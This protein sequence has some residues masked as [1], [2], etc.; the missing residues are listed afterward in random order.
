MEVLVPLIL[1]IVILAFLGHG[2]WVL[3]AWLLRA[4]FGVAAQR[5]RPGDSPQLCPRCLSPQPNKWDVCETCASIVARPDQ[6]SNVAL[7]A[8]QNHLDRLRTLGVLDSATYERFAQS[9]VAERRELMLPNDAPQSLSTIPDSDQTEVTEPV[10]AEAV[11]PIGPS[12]LAEPVK[13][14]PP[15]TPV[16]PDDTGHEPR[17]Q[18]ERIREFAAKFR[19]PIADEVTGE[20]AVP[21]EPSEPR[22]AVSKL[23]AAFM[24]EHSIRWGEI[25]GGLLII[26]CSIALVISFWSEIAARPLLKFFI[27]NSVTA[28]LFAVGFYTDRRWQLQ[29]TSVG[30][31]I[32]AILLVPLNVLAIAAFT[33]ASPPSDVL[34]IVGELI[35]LIVFSAFTYFAARTVLPNTA[36]PAAIGV[37]V[38][39]VM[40]LLTRRFVHLDA[41]YLTLYLLALAPIASYWVTAGTGLRWLD[42]DEI[43]ADACNELFILFGLVTYATVLPLALFLYK[44]WPSPN[45]IHDMSPV[46]SLFAV[47]AVVVGVFAGRRLATPATTTARVVGTATGCAGGVLMGIAVFAAWPHPATLLPVTLIPGLLFLALAT[48]WKLPLAFYPTSLSMLVVWP[49]ILSVL[50]GTIGWRS[51]AE[52][53]MASMLSA[54]TG[55]LLIPLAGVMAA[56]AALLARREQRE[57]ARVVGIS[58][59]FVAAVCLTLVTWFGFGR[60]GDPYGITWTFAAIAIGTYAAA[61]WVNHYGLTWAAAAMILGAVAQGALFRWP[62]EGT[63]PIR[64]ALVALIHASICTILLGFAAFAR[65]ASQRTHRATQQAALVTSFVASVLLIIAWNSDGATAVLPIAAWVTAIWFFLAFSS[66]EPSMFAAFQTALVVTLLCISVR[67]AETDSWYATSRL[68]WLHPH[69][70]QRLG[71]LLSGFALAWSALRWWMP[72][73]APDSESATWSWDGFV[74]RL[75]GLVHDSRSCVDHYVAAFIIVLTAWLALYASVPGVAQELAPRVG[76][77]ATTSRFVPPIH[78]FEI[79]NVPSAEAGQLASWG[80]WV[81]AMGV[82]LARSSQWTSGV[83]KMLL[84]LLVALACPLASAR[85]AADVSV[86]SGLR[87][88]LAVFFLLASIPLWMRQRFPRSLA[89]FAVP[90]TSRR[91]CGIRE[92]TAA[93]CLILA[94]VL[95]PHLVMAIY[96]GTSAVSLAGVPVPVAGVLPSLSVVAGF[97]ILISAGMLVASRQVSEPR[98][99]RTARSMWLSHAG[100]AIAFVGIAPVLVAFLF[101]VAASLMKHPIV[102]PEPGSWFGQVGWSVAYVVPLLIIAV[103]LVGDAVRERS[104][105]LAFG[106]GILFQVAATAG[107]MLTLPRLGRT[108]DESAWINVAQINTIVAGLVSLSWLA[109]L[110]VVHRGEHVLRFAPKLLTSYVVISAT[111][112]L[113]TLL[114][115]LGQLWLDQVPAEWVMMVGGWL[116]WLAF[117]CVSIAMIWWGG[118]TVGQFG[119]LEL[120][121]AMLSAVIMAAATIARWDTSN[122]LAYHTVEL[123]TIMA[124]IVVV[125][126]GWKWISHLVSRHG[127]TK[128]AIVPDRVLMTTE[129]AGWYG[130][131]SVLGVIFALRGAVAD[132]MAHW[133]SV[134]TIAAVACSSAL[135]AWNVKRRAL[136]LV[137]GV[138]WSIGGS[139]WWLL[140]QLP[141]YTAGIVDVPIDFLHFNLV[142]ASVPIAF[143]LVFTRAKIQIQNRGSITVSYHGFAAVLGILTFGL[144]SGVGLAA[145]LIG[146]PL[147]NSPWLGVGAWLVLMA[148]AIGWHV[149]R[150]GTA[151]ALITYVVG[152]LGLGLLQDRLDTT[153][154]LFWWSATMLLAAYGLATSYLWSQREKLQDI[155]ASTAPVPATDVSRSA[156]PRGSLDGQSPIGSFGWIVL[157]NGCLAAIVVAL[158]GWIDLTFETLALRVPASHAVL[159]QAFSLALL[160]KGTTRTQLQ[161]AAL[162]LGAVFAGVF[163]WSWLQPNMEATVLH[164]AVVVVV[165][166]SAVAIVYGFGLIKLFKRRNDWVTAAEHLVPV[167]V[168]VGFMTLLFVAGCEVWHYLNDERVPIQ[169]AAI[170]AV[171]IAL[172]GVCVACLAAALLPGRDPIGLSERGREV[173]VYAAEFVLALLCMHIRITMPW[174]FHGWFTRFWPLI[175]MGIAF[176]GVGYGELMLRRREGVLAHPLMTTGALLPVL[177]VLSWVFPSQVNYAVTL[178]SVAAL[179]ATLS[180]LRKSFLYAVLATVA[181]NGSLWYL[182]HQ[183]EELAF[184]RHPQFWLIPPALCTLV[185]SHLCRRQLTDNQLTSIRYAAAIVIYVASTADIFVNGVANAPWLPLVL[186]AFS[187]VGVFAGIML[188]VR[189]FLYLGVSFLMVSLF[190]IIWYAA[191]EL[192]RT[193]IWWVTGIVTGILIIILFAVFEKRRDDMLKLVENLKQWES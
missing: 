77:D 37:M 164:H 172:A 128:D 124:L 121:A 139:V 1:A 5:N 83:C 42:K 193:W 24:E 125:T 141:K 181:A 166:I 65:R 58:A 34:S 18:Y 148:T 106:A 62:I 33:D 168:A 171:A 190:T 7:T 88:A 137:A 29:T 55:N 187:L 23:L 70:L 104:A 12:S 97:A 176:L 158:V 48:S 63:G 53:L 134:G 123:A 119:V 57:E 117:G 150:Q 167:L 35:S 95:V 46:M 180:T 191:V 90:Q 174:L 45:S 17:D 147:G 20:A 184:V 54:P 177:P 11:E 98:Q 25:V 40:Q 22:V 9:I 61:T 2:L 8:I 115:A 27:F 60:L 26:C 178:L 86:A 144:S 10:V 149:E 69:F 56:A 21:T 51:S 101:T 163:G 175:A 87:W 78:D 81:I 50:R 107:F 129:T 114:P 162:G 75:G 138:V 59:G 146:E 105:S 85:W 16:G 126:G 6:K 130:V 19:T 72:S 183:V 31:L 157:A 99:T 131:F 67:S 91:V 71:F 112:L 152:L 80:L 79:P 3:G 41:S 43:N 4:I 109:Y 64:F 188:R 156:S 94:I 92:V 170:V 102:G 155:L 13:T 118:V 169:W 120:G 165:A 116:G 73:C 185:A 103:T 132:N 52:E 133:W 74:R 110:T 76:I 192:E 151:T 182:L 122:W 66:N 179:Y 15:S 145:D 68:P 143:S 153:G 14:R 32:I 159:A 173:Y 127:V 93:H 49:L 135:L 36:L 30:I 39:S 100:N 160:A 108:L 89:R 186:A 189:A 113:L 28:G 142:L 38:P 82:V 47:P 140:V 96:V 44:I 161:Y 136:V 84:W 154:T 111:L